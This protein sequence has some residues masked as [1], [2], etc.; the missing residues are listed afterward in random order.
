M[1]ALN[2]VACLPDSTGYAPLN[3]LFLALI[4]FIVF[5]FPLKREDMARD[6]N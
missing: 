3:V 2:T 1:F 4:L 6:L 5:C